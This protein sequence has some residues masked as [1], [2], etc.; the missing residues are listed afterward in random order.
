MLTLAILIFFAAIIC[1]FS[2]ELIRLCKSIFA[3]KGAKIFLPLAIATW[4]VYTFLP[5]VLWAI[6]Y[7]REIFIE[8][9]QVIEMLI[10][11]ALWR[12]QSSMVI[13]LTLIAVGPVAIWNFILIRRTQ[14]GLP[15]SYIISLFIWLI[16]SLILL[17]V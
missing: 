16:C 17:M 11:I 7:I 5:W 15:N 2:Q 13:L 4:G 1:F 9:M 12:Q 14:R 8:V 6:Y 3:I 10:P